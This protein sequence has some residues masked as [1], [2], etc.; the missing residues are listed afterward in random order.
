MAKTLEQQAN[1]L[2]PLVVESNIAALSRESGVSE[3]WIRYFVRGKVPNAGVQTLDKIIR[4]LKG[5]K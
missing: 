2:K 1:D 3:R 4:A 5:K